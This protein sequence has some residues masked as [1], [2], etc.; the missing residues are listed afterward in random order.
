MNK[1][2]IKRI[3]QYILEREKIIQNNTH[4]FKDIQKAKNE[5]ENK[6]SSLSFEEILMMDEYITMQQLKNN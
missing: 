4:S 3:A 1:K 5:I 6:I 2:H